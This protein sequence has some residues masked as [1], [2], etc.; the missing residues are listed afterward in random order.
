MLSCSCAS[1]AAAFAGSL[2][3]GMHYTD[4]AAGG[5]Q[6]AQ[7]VRDCGCLLKCTRCCASGM[8]AGAAFEELLFSPPLL[9]CGCAVLC[10]PCRPEMNMARLLRSAQRLMLADFEPQVR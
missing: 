4:M 9:R 7:C 6:Q 8:A 5:Q 10:V 3:S 1:L 2:H